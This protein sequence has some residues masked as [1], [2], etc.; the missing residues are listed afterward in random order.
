MTPAQ[1][2]KLKQTGAVVDKVFD[3]A[4]AAKAGL[5]AGDIITAVAGRPVQD[6]RTLQAIVV[7]LAV[8]KPVAMSV[9]RNGKTLIMTV[10]I[11][12]L[13]EDFGMTPPPMPVYNKQPKEGRSRE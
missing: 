5:K 8:G 12:E 3:N 2:A 4:P 10:T 13:P 1:A 6:T 11:T 9:F 7:S